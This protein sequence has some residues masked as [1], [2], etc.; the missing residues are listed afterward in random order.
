MSFE[1][2]S[3]KNKCKYF[4]VQ[5]AKIN[6]EK[7]F[8]ES[9]FSP[10]ACNKNNNGGRIAY[11][12]VNGKNGIIL[13]TAATEGEEFEAQND[14]SYLGKII[15]F[16]DE[17]KNPQII[18]KGHRNPQGLY[19]DGELILLTEHGPYGGD[20]INK[21]VPNKNYGWPISSYGETYDFK[22]GQSEFN[23]FKSHNKKNFEEPVFSFV[24]SIGISEIIKIP[25]NF[26]RYWNDNFF[27]TSLNG[28]S[29]FRIKFDLNFEKVIFSEKII[30][31]SR[32]RDII[33]IKEINSFALAM[34]DY[35]EIWLLKTAN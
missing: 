24:P 9:F 31:L 26:S 6:Q 2:S 33:Y 28:S 34:E 19:A 5:K 17:D 15:F 21:I 30:L 4:S 29:L 12:K 3:L 7:L 14:N 16:S 11:G 27:V 23:Y 22:I 20:E 35:G 1:F 8:F 13:S 25:N 32:I 10:E 18:S